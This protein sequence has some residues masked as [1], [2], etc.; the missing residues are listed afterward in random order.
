MKPK[1]RLLAL[2]L[3]LVPLPAFAS[4]SAPD[5]GPP[6]TGASGTDL[7]D[8]SL[9]ELMDIEISSVSKRAQP[10]S[11]IPAAVHVISAEHIRRSGAANIPEALRLAPGV[12]VARFSNNRWSVS[13]RSFGGRFASKLLVLQDG[14]SLYSPLFSGVFWE[15][16]DIPL[17]L[18]ERIE[19]V[20][21]PGASLWGANAV[22]G[23]INII[24]RNAAS[25]QGTQVSAAAGTELHGGLFASHGLALSDTTHLEVH[26]RS[27]YVEPSSTPED[28]RA[29][30]F[31]RTRQA[32]FRLDGKAA[33]DRF[34]LQG[35]VRD[36]MTGEH[37]MMPAQ[38]GR[39]PFLPANPSNELAY[40]LGRWDHVADGGVTHSVQA[41]VEQSDMDIVIAR[42]QRTTF[43]IEYQQQQ[44]L[45]ERVDFI[46]GA[47]WR[48]K[49]DEV[50]G[51][52]PRFPSRFDSPR[53]RNDLFNLF[54]QGEFQLVPERWALTLGA[55]VDRPDDA[56]LAFQP[57]AR[58]LFTPDSTHSLWASAARAVRT[59]SRGE[60]T[61][62]GQLPA[63]PLE[64][65]LTLDGNT[66]TRLA[67]RINGN[68]D[69]GHE[70]LDA[71]DLGW[72]ASWSSRLSTELAAYH[73]RYDDLRHA[74]RGALI[75]LTPGVLT[76]TLTLDS[77]ERAR[78]SGIELSTQWRPTDAWD[79]AASLSMSRM[80]HV[81]V[82]GP[83][84]FTEGTPE[85]IFTLR[86]GYAISPT[87][88]W[89][90]WLRHASATQTYAFQPALR[91]DP[92]W[93]LDMRL[94]WKASRELELSL[95]G[96][97]LLDHRHLEAINEPLPSMIHEVERGVYL[98]ADWRL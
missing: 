62:S 81:S 77:T 2:A 37:F 34:R 97:N 48:H 52:A 50:V 39:I 45:G 8:L 49:R 21:G 73:Y 87:L 84:E 44:R 46:W 54:A 82:E 53:D 15:F 19:I 4:P 58:L 33:A 5:T 76:Q 61:V 91:V 66:Y 63:K 51:G 72:R 47:G 35:S 56:R 93:T 88:Q 43:D 75:P 16:N 23:V 27:H 3:A 67:P 64:S 69:F 78:V 24:T 31:W 89:D 86:T 18:V 29:R 65:P 13:I 32:G 68:P 90:A 12:H 14:R 92:Y 95:V 96:Q 83:T 57:N 9:E 94:G 36:S 22:N 25:A 42:E 10:L 98:R 7:L 85:R 17:E 60:R 6:D 41:Y 28:G 38:A 20:R 26:A 74:H 11:R 55:R 71:L 30:D 79:L 1:L 40:L 80:S 70:Y 59:G